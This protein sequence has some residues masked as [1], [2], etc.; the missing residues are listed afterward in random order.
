[1]YD[2]YQKI[3]FFFVQKDENSQLFNIKDH[4]SVIEKKIPL[5]DDQDCEFS[6]NDMQECLFSYMKN[7]SISFQE[8]LVSSY[9]KSNKEKDMDEI[10]SIINKDESLIKIFLEKV[11]SLEKIEIKKINEE[12]KEYLDLGRK[13]IGSLQILSYRSRDQEFEKW[14]KEILS[15][16]KI[17]DLDNKIM[18]ILNYFIELPF[19]IAKFLKKLNNLIEE[20]GKIENPDDSEQFESFLEE[21]SKEIEEFIIILHNYEKKFKYNFKNKTE[22]ENLQKISLNLIHVFIEG[23]QFFSTI[24]RNKLEQ[25]EQLDFKLMLGN[26]AFFEKLKNFQRFLLNYNSFFEQY[27]DELENIDTIKIFEI[28]KKNGMKFSSTFEKYM[29]ETFFYKF[30]VEFLLK[31]N[32]EFLPLLSKGKM[33]EIRTK[34]DDIFEKIDVSGSVTKH[35]LSNFWNVLLNEIN[36]I[37]TILANFEQIR[38]FINNYIEIE[39]TEP[40]EKLSEILG[41]LEIKLLHEKFELE[42]WYLVLQKISKQLEE[43]SLE[44]KSDGLKNKKEYYIKEL[45]ELGKKN[46]SQEANQFITRISEFILLT[47]KLN[48]F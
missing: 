13:K 9:L 8:M 18:N 47:Y 4:F 16:I 20:Q 11:E 19:K 32:I 24:L 42:S 45:R 17:L 5:M 40:H 33:K 44:L 21:F 22:I 23:F 15:R 37:Y 28:I 38:K 34:I 26:P 29:E 46:Q 30:N 25:N 43:I 27:N 7:N 35:Y 2:E 3:E 36:E 48:D 14:K 41:Y 39:K 6:R 12:I 1:M 10:N 31:M